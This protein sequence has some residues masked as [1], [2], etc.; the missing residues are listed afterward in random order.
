MRPENVTTLCRST[1]ISKGPERCSES[2][3]SSFSA[4]IDAINV[5]KNHKEAVPH[6]K[7][8]MDDEIQALEGNETW[9]MISPPSNVS[10][11]G[12]KWF[13]SV[14]LRS[15]GTIDRYKVRLVAQGYKQE[16]GIDYEETYAPVAKMT[17]V[18][19]LIALSA[20]HN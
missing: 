6:L 19:V 17:I 7:R 12:S 2:E 11:I 8:A 9:E 3:Y 13:C 1:R 10:I 18:R 5:P 4:E 15:D 20:V 16:Q 14:E